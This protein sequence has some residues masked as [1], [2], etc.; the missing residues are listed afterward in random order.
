MGD[1]Q[2]VLAALQL[3]DNGF[4]PDDDV[5]VR[6]AA[7]IAIVVLVLVALFEILGVFLFNLRVRETIADAGIEFVK[8]FPLELFKRQESC[9][10]DRSF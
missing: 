8:R 6:L 9:C 2:D 10:L 7:K 1:N 3:H 5:T 4:Q